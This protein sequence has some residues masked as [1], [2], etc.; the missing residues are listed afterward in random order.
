M[1]RFILIALLLGLL[2]ACE[3]TEVI[4]PGERIAIRASAEIEKLAV[5]EEAAGEGA[6]LSAV[7]SNPRFDTAGFD[8]GH[9]GGHFKIDFPLERAFSVLVGEAAEIGTELA[10]PVANENAVFTVM[11][12]GIVTATSVKDGTRLW[13]VDIDPSEDTTQTSLSGGMSLEEERLIVHAGKNRVVALNTESG[14]EEWSTTLPN[15]LAGGPS[16]AHE[17][18]IVTDITG[19]VY[20][21]FLGSGEELWNR[22]GAEGRTRIT[23]AAFPAIVENEVII[24]GG[25]GEI[26]ALNL[27]TGSYLWGEDLTPLRLLTALDT[28]GDIVAHPVHDGRLVVAIT[29]SGVMAVFGAN[30]GRTLWEQNLRSLRMPWLAGETMFVSTVNN[31]LYALRRQDGVVRWKVNLSGSFDLAESVSP[32]APRYTAPIVIGGRVVVGSDRGLLYIY[33]AETGAS[34]GQIGTGDAITTDLI[35]A[36]GTLYALGRRGRLQAYRPR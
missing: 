27:D 14:E 29:Q 33:D 21:L 9:S 32:N 5:N 19:R 34:Q 11:P 12:G 25:D 35:V 16:I 26:V 15:F 13:Q 18:V 22:I 20:A 31:Q 3:E 1:M 2:S 8:D 24:V 36:S 4:L 17:R 28:I 10:Q 23:G 6:R 30:T 7:V